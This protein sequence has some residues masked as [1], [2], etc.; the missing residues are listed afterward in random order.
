MLQGWCN[1]SPRD[2]EQFFTFGDSE[3]EGVVVRESERGLELALEVGRQPQRASHP[4]KAASPKPFPSAHICLQ[5]VLWVIL[6]LIRLLC[7]CS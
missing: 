7:L 5:A 1:S 4:C 6:G 3:R 2:W